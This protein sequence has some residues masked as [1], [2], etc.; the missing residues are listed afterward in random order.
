MKSYEVSKFIAFSSTIKEK[1]CAILRDEQSKI[2]QSILNEILLRYDTANKNGQLDRVCRKLE[3]GIKLNRTNNE[4]V[5]TMGF[6][7]SSNANTA[8]LKSVSD[9]DIAV[10]EE[11]E[12]IRDVHKYRKFADGIRKEGYLIVIVLNTADLQHWITKTYF[13]SVP[14]TFEDIP[15]PN[16]S[17]LKDVI[18]EKDLEGYFKLTPRKRPGFICI[19]TS[20][21]DNQ[22]LPET[23]ITEYENYG[24]PLDTTYD[25]HHYLT[26]ILGFSSSGRKGQ[27]L[28]KVEKISLKEYLALPFKEIYGQDFGTASPAGLVGVKFNGKNSYCREIN[29]LPMHVKE[30]G[31]LYCRL[32]FNDTDKI[33]ADNAE[34]DTIEK[35]KNGWKSKE[36]DGDEIS[37]YPKLLKGF[38]IEGCDKG[39]GSVETGISQ[40]LGM[41]LFAVTESLNLWNEINNWVYD[42]DKNGNPTDEPAPGFD[43]LID[44]WRYVIKKYKPQTI[45]DLSNFA[46][47]FG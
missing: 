1:R 15:E 10:I 4:V 42:T 33:I 14:I 29:Y 27:I 30:I 5:F 40:M 8:G 24:N 3:T 39:T 38:F 35:L 2:R 31:K 44:G 23:K 19:Q 26:D 28:K 9:V 36:L 25:L 34:P 13:E 16:Y 21:K 41:N 37:L 18:T 22:W 6:K 43:H 47:A 45:Q 17:L 46:G 12:D 20:Y 11:A 32:K 7:A